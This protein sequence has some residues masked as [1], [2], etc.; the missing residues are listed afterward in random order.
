MK[1]KEHNVEIIT[2]EPHLPLEE[3]KP[4]YTHTELTYTSKPMH[5]SEAELCLN[6][7]IMVRSEC[8]STQRKRLPAGLMSVKDHPG[9]KGQHQ[10]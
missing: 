5:L 3:A 1:A 4:E 10:A 6:K 8:F 9:V 2:H 7:T